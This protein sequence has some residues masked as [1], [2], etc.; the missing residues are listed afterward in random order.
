MIQ[1]TTDHCSGVKRRTVYG[2]MWKNVKSIALSE[3]S[4]TKPPLTWH[5]QTVFALHRAGVTV[6]V[7]PPLVFRVGAGFNHVLVLQ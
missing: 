1:W 4:Q 3:I 7:Q 2:K 6:P 5:S